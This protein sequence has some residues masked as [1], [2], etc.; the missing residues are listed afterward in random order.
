MELLLPGS[1]KASS[2]AA[3]FPHAVL[4]GTVLWASQALVNCAAQGFQISWHESWPPS[5]CGFTAP[6]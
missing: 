5:A 6:T 2:C 3:S 4:A 1:A